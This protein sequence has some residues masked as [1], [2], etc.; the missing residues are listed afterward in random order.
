MI[1]T[2]K[3]MGRPSLGSGPVFVARQ[4][5]GLSQTEMAERLGVGIATI[6]RCE[7]DGVVPQSAA[8]RKILEGM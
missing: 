1:E 2:Q 8:S 5:H 3:K 7:R 4:A 6:K